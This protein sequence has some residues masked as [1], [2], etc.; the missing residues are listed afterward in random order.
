MAIQWTS[1][2][3]VVVDLE[4]L[5]MHIGDR[6]GA[7]TVTVNSVDPS[8]LVQI[9]SV[10]WARYPN[11]FAVRCVDVSLRLATSSHA[12][13]S[14]GNPSTSATGG[15]VNLLSFD[16]TAGD[17]TAVSTV[18]MTNVTA[19]AVDDASIQLWSRTTIVSNIASINIARVDVMIA[20]MT[21]APWP[22]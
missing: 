21:R 2:S 22:H 3:V 1:G 11:L 15:T 16:L 18:E 19:G 4:R 5:T 17:A 20:N 14:F 12:D 13:V 8:S 6:A 7:V 9:L 10:G